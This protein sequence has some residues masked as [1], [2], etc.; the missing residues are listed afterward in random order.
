[1]VFAG[2]AACVIVMLAGVAA[3]CP[4]LDLVRMVSWRY[5]ALNCIYVSLMVYMYPE[6]YIYG[7]PVVS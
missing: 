3:C 1:M 6:W 4:E 7:A 5:G 2:V